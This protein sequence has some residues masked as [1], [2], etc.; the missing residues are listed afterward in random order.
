M[1]AGPGTGGP[2]TVLA[3]QQVEVEKAG[4]AR[5]AT[6]VNELSYLSILLTSM[7]LWIGCNK[8]GCGSAEIP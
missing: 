3:H 1:R 4:R 6:S 8:R 2:E 5:Q 7:T